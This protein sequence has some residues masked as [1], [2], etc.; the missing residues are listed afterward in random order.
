MTRTATIILALIFLL[1]PA[2]AFDTR[3]LGQWGSLDL[4]D[5][6]E[7]IGKAPKLRAE[8]DAALAQAKKT[9][10][11]VKCVGQRFPGPWKELGGYRVAPYTCWFADDK[12]LNISADVKVIDK[13]GHAF[14]EP[15]DRAM[16]R[17]VKFIEGR[18]TWNWTEKD[19]T[20]VFN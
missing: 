20:G 5:L 13:R 2:L 15:S 9:A 1:Q 6:D 16:K 11:Q 8:V 7:L 3:K 4:S 19:P 17:A 18:P 14:T 10:E 12:W